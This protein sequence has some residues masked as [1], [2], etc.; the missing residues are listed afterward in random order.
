MENEELEGRDDRTRSNDDVPKPNLPV[1][2]R[3]L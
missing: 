1:S 3:Q 2:N